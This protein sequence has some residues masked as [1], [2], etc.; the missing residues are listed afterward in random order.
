MLPTDEAR[1]TEYLVI[2]E[3]ERWPTFTDDMDWDSLKV[4]VDRSIIY[5]NRLPENRTFR[6][7]NETYSLQEMKDSLFLLRDMLESNPT[8]EDLRERMRRKFDLYQ[9]LG[10]KGDGSVLFTGYYEPILRGSRNK[11]E[12][13]RYP[14]YQTPD[15]HT[16]IHLGQFHSKYEGE[17]IVA[18][19]DDGVVLPYY[20]RGDI[21]IGRILDGRDLEIAWTDDPVDLFFMHIQG[22][23]TI[24]FD[25]GDSIQVSYAQANG[26]P[27]RSLG[28][29]LAQKGILTMAEVSLR[30]IKNY[31]HNSDEMMPILAHNE[32]YVFFRVVD[33]GPRGAID[34]PV[35][36]GR[37]IATDPAYF[38]RGSL[39]LISVKYPQFSTTGEIESW[40][41][42]WRLV[43]NQDAGGAI[44]GPG[45]VD[46]FWGTGD[47]A[48]LSAGYMKEFGQL[49]FLVQKR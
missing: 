37:S 21:D 19:I 36:A 18:R 48:G 2:V 44:K 15:D 3:A 7:G 40:K 31:L 20:T 38:P 23:G 22:S 16:V 34:V 27:Y 14:I 42:F 49:Y 47:E 8:S 6:M 39:A 26:R 11:T 32:S 1:E 46:L 30:G 10:R 41:P 28:R 12:L 13:Y 4:A 29:F 45:R 43:L 5:Y 17:R 24:A 25:D 9:S 33:E 35:T